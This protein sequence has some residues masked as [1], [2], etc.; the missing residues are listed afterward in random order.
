MYLNIVFDGCPLHTL[1]T[2][3][4]SNRLKESS[5]IAPWNVEIYKINNYG[6]YFR[7]CGGTLIA[8]NLVVSGKK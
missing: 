4:T 3:S 8:P 5:V 6:R 1:G 2:E 7:V